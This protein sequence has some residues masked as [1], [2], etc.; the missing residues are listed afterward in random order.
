VDDVVSD[1]LALGVPLVL[2]TGGEPLEQVGC[3]ALAGKLCDAGLSVLVETGGHVDLSPLDPRVIRIVDVKCPASQMA[4][5]NRLENLALIRA[6]DEVKFVVADR[7]DVE[8]AFDIIQRHDLASRGCELLLSPV[9][10]QLDPAQLAAWI[11]AGPVPTARLSLQQH[12]YI[13]PQSKRGV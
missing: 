13:W 10:G 4:K 8:F 9:H 3:L 12:K 11:L 2:L 6:L 7:A 1:V 5:R